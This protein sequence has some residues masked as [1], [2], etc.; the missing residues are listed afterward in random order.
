[1]LD[2]NL[3]IKRNI[4][5]YIR[6][7][8][9]VFFSF[10]SVIILLVLYL[11]FLKNQYKM[12]FLLELIN[13]KQLDFLING[14]IMGGILVINTLTIALGN[15]GNIVDDF[16]SNKIDSFVVTPTKPIR[17]V[18]AYYLSS[19]FITLVF[20]LLMWF[21]TVLIT[22]LTTGIWFHINTI[23]KVSFLMMLYTLI[24][25]A[26]MVLVTTFIKSTSAFGA[27]SGVFGTMIGF[28][29][30]IYIPL[31][32]LPNNI[33]KIS[34]LIPFTHMTIYLKEVLTRDIMDIIEPKLS[35]DQ[36]HSFKDAFSMNHLKILNFNL[37][38]NTIILISLAIALL[39][40]MIAS[41]RLVKR[42]ETH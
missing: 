16:H 4:K 36:M 38:M 22:G 7:K 28:L 11:L 2:I 20:T 8:T 39:C 41:K 31:A 3:M 42:I 5:I 23:I 34:S 14:T 25:T 40:I 1:M 21:L 27:V 6:D 17:I 13:E 33:Q 9:A 37:S 10:L 29:C 15:L 32:S 18:I 30:G 12:D 24:S 19:F 26:F 35:V